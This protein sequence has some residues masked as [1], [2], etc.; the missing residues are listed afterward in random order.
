MMCFSGAVMPLGAL[1][2]TRP[3]DTCGTM[4]LADISLPNN[5]RYIGQE[6]PDACTVAEWKRLLEDGRLVGEKILW[7]RRLRCS[8]GGMAAEALEDADALPTQPQPVF[9][10]GPDSVITML[11]SFLSRA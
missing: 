10:Y 3:P 5:T 6:V 7:A 8:A 11:D 2:G 1:S 4:P 9:V